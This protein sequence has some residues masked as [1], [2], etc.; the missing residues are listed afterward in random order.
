MVEK[1]QGRTLKLK[2]IK[3]QNN[4][5]IKGKPLIDTKLIK[6]PRGTLIKAIVSVNVHE[7]SIPK[8]KADPVEIVIS[9]TITPPEDAPLV[10]ECDA[11]VEYYLNKMEIQIPYKICRT[12]ASLP[13]TVLTHITGTL[14]KC[15]T[16]VADLITATT[17]Y[18]RASLDMISYFIHLRPGGTLLVVVMRLDPG[19]DIPVLALEPLAALYGV[20]TLRALKAALRDIEVNRG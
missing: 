6:I 4:S 8:K 7:D 17:R 11:L 3:I 15:D 18:K 5:T 10:K 1:H 12:A 19:D 20:N 13:Q 16:L 9:K 14:R 2:N